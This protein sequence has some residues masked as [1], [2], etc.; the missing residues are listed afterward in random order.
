MQFCVKYKAEVKG[1]LDETVKS[2]MISQHLKIVEVQC[3]LVDQRVLKLLKFFGTLNI[4][5][6]MAN[7]SFVSLSMFGITIW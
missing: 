1:H 2:T 4:C 5:K 7:F 3:E 6:T